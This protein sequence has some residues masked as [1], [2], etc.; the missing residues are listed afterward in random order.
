LVRG[1]TLSLVFSIIGTTSTADLEKEEQ[2][3]SVSK[4][5]Q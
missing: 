2:K 3:Q 5:C 1:Q 4:H